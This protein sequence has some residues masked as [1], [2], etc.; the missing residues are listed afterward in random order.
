MDRLEFR[1]SLTKKNWRRLKARAKDPA[2][3][4]ARAFRLPFSAPPV[5]APAIV[6]VIVTATI[7]ASGTRMP[8]TPR[9]NGVPVQGTKILVVEDTSGSMG[10]ATAELE[11]QKERFGRSLFQG[12]S[13]VHGF[14]VVSTGEGRNL[15]HVLAVDLPARRSIDTVYVFSDFKPIDYDIDCNDAVG[16]VQFRQLIRRIGV[17]LYLSTVSMMPSSGLLAIAKESGGALIGTTPADSLAARRLVC[18]IDQ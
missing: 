3:P 1:T 5:E 2:N 15:L 18:R 7:L 13:E 10:Q 6:L 9:V 4:L 16:L 12:K 14:G 11:R 17:R 8:N